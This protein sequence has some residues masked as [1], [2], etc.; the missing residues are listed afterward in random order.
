[1]LLLSMDVKLPGVLVIRAGLAAVLML[2]RASFSVVT[3]PASSRALLSIVAAASELEKA[4]G[5]IGRR[6]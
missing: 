3:P 4:G 1:M 5:S 6:L 2:P